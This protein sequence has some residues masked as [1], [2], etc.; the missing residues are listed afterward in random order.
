S[1]RRHTR[2]YGDWSSDVCSSDLKARRRGA[3]ASSVRSLQADGRF[4]DLPDPQLVALRQQI[5]LQRKSIAEAEEWQRTRLSA[6]NARLA[7]Q[8]ATLGP[9]HPSVLDTQDE[10]QAVERR[11]AQ[12]QALKAQEQELLSRYVREGGKEIEL[13]PDAPAW[14]LELKED[15][16][17]ITYAKAQLAM[18]MTALQRL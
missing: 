17:A 7:E 10:L 14:P 15:D 5:V 8:R 16:A 6:L 4:R 12:I 2:S 1:R 9:A 11:G 13:L 18:E 3:R